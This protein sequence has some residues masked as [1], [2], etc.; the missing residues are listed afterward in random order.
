MDR[1]S[2]SFNNAKPADMI[3]QSTALI[4]QSTSTIIHSPLRLSPST[5]KMRKRVCSVEFMEF[6]EKIKQQLKQNRKCI[7]NPRSSKWVMWWDT[8]TFLCLAFTALVTPIEVCLYTDTNPEISTFFLGL[9]ICNRVVD[10][11]FLADLVLNFFLAYQ[12]S[13]REGGQWVTDPPM[14]RRHYLR[15]WFTVD[16]LSMLPFELLSQLGFMEGGL[17]RLVRTIRLLRLVKLL[18]IL[19][20]NA[21]PQQPPRHAAQRA[22]ARPRSPRRCAVRCGP[23]PNASVLFLA[24]RLWPQPHGSLRAGSRTSACR[25]PWRR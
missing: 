16:V 12:E 13:P 8:G 1:A 23:Q 15:T 22:R 14:I 6:H 21:K 3:R 18:R 19:R 25:T 9:F 17:L 7:V 4:R 2:V 10:S 20:G 24:A 5:P 11:F